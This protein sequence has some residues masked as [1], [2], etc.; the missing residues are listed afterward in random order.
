[1]TSTGTPPSAQPSR[2]DEGEKGFSGTGWTEWLAGVTL[3]ENWKKGR[4]EQRGTFNG[5]AKGRAGGITK[6]KGK[7]A[8]GSHGVSK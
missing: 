4:T 6:R 8:E 1:V 2:Q 5:G 3:H 7:L